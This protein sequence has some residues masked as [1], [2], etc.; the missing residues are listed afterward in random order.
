MQTETTNSQT[1]E[2][3]KSNK[4]GK[5][6]A[7]KTETNAAPVS[8]IV[9]LSSQHRE[10]EALFDEIEKAGDRAAKKKEKIFAMI[11][12]KLTVHAKIEELIFYPAAKE[13]D[14]DLVLEAAEEHANVKAMIRKLQRTEG[15]DETFDAKVK[16]LK[17][18]V[19]H[20][21][22][23]EEQELFPKCRGALG[24]E[25]LLELGAKL[26]AKFEQLESLH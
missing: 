25:A 11:A 18:L 26:Q 9:Y 2:S 14:E 21:V 12:D 22:K 17:E 13:A 6:K 23:E 10:V 4:Q 5:S 16:V 19:G 20:H 8:A 15:S 24:D 3:K 1:Q 7:A